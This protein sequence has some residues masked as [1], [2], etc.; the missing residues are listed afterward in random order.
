MSL[1]K[2][3]LCLG[4][5]VTYVVVLFCYLCLGCVPLRTGAVAGAGAATCG[6]AARCSG[7]STMTGVVV[8]GRRALRREARRPMGCS[9]PSDR[10]SPSAA[11]PAAARPISC[12]VVF[13]FAVIFTNFVFLRQNKSQFFVICQ[14]KICD[15]VK[16]K[17]HKFC[18]LA[19]QIHKICVQ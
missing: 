9:R 16:E 7:V 12:G 10:E 15:L 1:Q 11:A 17:I 3:N 6:S 8:A 14:H 5:C 13:R 2:C 4:T 18:D 19:L